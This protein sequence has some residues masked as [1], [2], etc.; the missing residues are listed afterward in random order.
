VTYL[1]LKGRAARL[2]VLST[3][4]SGNTGY[5]IVMVPPKERKIP[6]MK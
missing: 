6:W 1:K 2:K 4:K 3:S 5:R